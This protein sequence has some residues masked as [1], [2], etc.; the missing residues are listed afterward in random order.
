MHIA[1]VIWEIFYWGFAMLR[2]FILLSISLLLVIAFSAC[3]V[4]ENDPAQP[5]SIQQTDQSIDKRPAYPSGPS[6]GIV[7]D[8]EVFSVIVQDQRIYVGV[9]WP[10][11]ILA[12]IIVI[13]YSKERETD[14][15]GFRASIIDGRNS[16]FEIDYSRL[17]NGS[18]SRVVESCGFDRLQIDQEWIS[19]STLKESYHWEGEEISFNFNPDTILDNPQQK[20]FAAEFQAFYPGSSLEDNEDGN[21][22]LSL[23]NSGSFW[24]IL[25]DQMIAQGFMVPED[26]FNW[27]DV[28]AGATIGAAIKCTFGGGIL[29]PLCI[30]ATCTSIAV[31]ASH[32]LCLIPGVDCNTAGLPE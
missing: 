10:D 17:A 21:R 7:R 15:H 19:E 9:R 28:G 22:L 1:V 6:I 18:Q 27:A 16:K 20:D 14:W 2:N 4:A 13:E 30:V 8:V 3:D 29:N 23:V 5:F 32:L 25:E 11:Q 31:A 26:K 24:Q 12:R